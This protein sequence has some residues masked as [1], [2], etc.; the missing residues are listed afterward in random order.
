MSIRLKIPIKD[1]KTLHQFAL[2]NERRLR[3]EI[4]GPGSVKKTR[5]GYG[6][7]VIRLENRPPMPG[8]RP[9]RFENEIGELLMLAYANNGLST[10]YEYVGIFCNE[11]PGKNQFLLNMIVYDVLDLHKFGNDDLDLVALNKKWIE[12]VLALPGID[13]M[14]IVC[15]VH[16][17]LFEKYIECLVKNG[18]DINE[19]LLY[20]DTLIWRTFSSVVFLSRTHMQTEKD[21]A[22]MCLRTLVTHGADIN[23]GLNTKLDHLI[24]I[25]DKELRSAYTGELISVWAYLKEIGFNFK[26]RQISERGMLYSSIIGPYIMAHEKKEWS[27]QDLCALTIVKKKMIT[28]GHLPSIAREWFG[29]R[30]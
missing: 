20:E 30:N 12:E 1:F 22:N 16:S 15:S 11:W 23:L 21:D 13:P 7:L 2:Q 3:K 19:K 9:R 4:Y 29:F 5:G 25:K 10:Y 14:D 24:R 26:N 18:Y 28:K 17:T 27:L 6:K 8:A